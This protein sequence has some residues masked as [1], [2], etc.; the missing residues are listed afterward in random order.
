MKHETIREKY[1]ALSILSQRVLPS[2]TSENKFANLLH[3]FTK[4]YKITE[5]HRKKAIT[6]HPTPEGW[7]EARLP[8]AVSEARQRAVDE[9]ME[10]SSPIGKI[11]DTL[12]L[13]NADLPQKL[14]REG[15]ESNVEGLA[16]LRVLLGSLYVPDEEY[17][18][19]NESTD[20]EESDEAE[21]AD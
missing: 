6:D 2:K 11:P 17:R 3:R 14:K 5:Q 13:T 8:H 20:G 15:G 12:R 9:Y 7:E 18:M 19:M 4:P 10:L 21:P 1:G 16:S